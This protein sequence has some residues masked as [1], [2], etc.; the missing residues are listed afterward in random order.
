MISPHSKAPLD[1]RWQSQ[2]HGD[3]PDFV[4]GTLPH[5]WDTNLGSLNG[6]KRKMVADCSV[7]SPLFPGAD[8][9]FV[10]TEAYTVWGPLFLKENITLKEQN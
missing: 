9:Y 4:G 8:L 10:G 5:C 6:A 2:G 3:T 7:I 1:C